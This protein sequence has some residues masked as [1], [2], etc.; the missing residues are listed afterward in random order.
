[1][2]FVQQAY[3]ELK[4]D[5]DLWSMFYLC[6]NLNLTKLTLLTSEKE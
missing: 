5:I 2:I 1:M 3:L 4:Q 6:L